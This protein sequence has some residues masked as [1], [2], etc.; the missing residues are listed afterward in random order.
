LER[1]T[2][3]VDLSFARAVAVNI[4]VAAAVAVAVTLVVAL[5]LA[6]SVAHAVCICIGDTIALGAV[7]PTSRQ[8]L[9]QQRRAGVARRRA[10]HGLWSGRVHN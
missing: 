10:R 2:L 1:G 5:A 4:A 8:H 9:P 7:H 3:R 6:F